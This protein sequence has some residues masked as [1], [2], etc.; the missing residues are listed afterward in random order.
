M[1]T[2]FQALRDDVT[3][4]A[5]AL[6]QKELGVTLSPQS[7]NAIADPDDDTGRGDYLE[8]NLDGVPIVIRRIFGSEPPEFRCLILNSPPHKNEPFT[9]AAFCEALR[10]AQPGIEISDVYEP[11][12]I[13]GSKVVYFD[14]P[15]WLK[16]AAANAT[17]VELGIAT[18]DDDWEFHAGDETSDHLRYVEHQ[19]FPGR[20]WL[21]VTGFLGDD[22][23][24]K[25]SPQIWC[26]PVLGE[27]SWYPMMKPLFEVARSRIGQ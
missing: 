25:V 6:V 9:R 7:W 17:R 16:A 18:E 26:P 21:R 14:R 22:G 10:A 13:N 27:N 12:V 4:H 20:L 15:E 23:T 2:R 1:Q 11:D 19:I 24:P 5:I 8:V 3:P